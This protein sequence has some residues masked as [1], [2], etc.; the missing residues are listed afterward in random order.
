MMGGRCG[1]VIAEPATNLEIEV[2]YW[3]RGNLWP[4]VAPIWHQ[5]SQGLKEKTDEKEEIEVE[6]KIVVKSLIIVQY[7]FNL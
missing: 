7:A 5:A 4:W 6:D 2:R 3:V 1:R